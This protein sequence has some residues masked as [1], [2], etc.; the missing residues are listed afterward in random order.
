MDVW[1]D[2]QHQSQEG[3]WDLGQAASQRSG[4]LSIK[5]DIA[6]AHRLESATDA[7]QDQLQAESQGLR[8]SSEVRNSTEADGLPE[9]F[10]WQAYLAYYPDLVSSGISSESEAQRHYLA[11]GRQEGRIHRRL[12]VLMHYTACTGLINQHYSHIAAFTLSSAI[13]AE[14]VLAPGLQRDSFASYFSAHKEQNEV[15]WTS[16]STDQL[17]DV[18]RITEEWRARGMDVHKVSIACPSVKSSVLQG[19]PRS[20]TLSTPDTNPCRS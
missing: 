17:L 1:T 14:L 2:Y 7:P 4:A 13:G 18:D 20:A 3:E 11:H 8:P 19:R 15:T 12:K 9:D 5:K 6:A 16:M 10:D